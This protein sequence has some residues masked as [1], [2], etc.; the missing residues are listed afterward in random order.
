MSHTADEPNTTEAHTD[1]LADHSATDGLG[2]DD[3]IEE[4]LLSDFTS[5][6]W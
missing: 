4:S 5:D 3:A 2:V 6:D 1:D